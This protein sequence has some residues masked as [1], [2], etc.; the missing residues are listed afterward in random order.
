MAN[1]FDV[2]LLIVANV[3]CDNIVCT[4]AD[5]LL[6]MPASPSVVFAWFVANV[7]CA[8]QLGGLFV[9]PL[10]ANDEIEMRNASEPNSVSVDAGAV[11]EVPTAMALIVSVCGLALTILDNT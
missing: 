2:V 10:V 7:H 9:K 8:C 6:K 11:V 1:V 5:V 4:F 3:T